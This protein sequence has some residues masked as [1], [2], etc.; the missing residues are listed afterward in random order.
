MNLWWPLTRA[1]G[2]VAWYSMGF[3]SIVGVVLST[4]LFPDRRRPAWLLDAHRWTAGIALVALFTHLVA[5]IADSYV[6]FGVREVLVPYAS[7]WRPGAVALGVVALWITIVIT[8]AAALR[9]RLPRPMWR[10]IHRGAYGAFLLTSLHAAMAGTDATRRVYGAGA[11]LLITAV[12]AA[13]VYRV[14]C[15]EPPKRTRPG[16][17]R[18][19]GAAAVDDG[20]S[21]G[22]PS[23]PARPA[24]PSAPPDPAAGASQPVVVRR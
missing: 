14:A 18:V 11:V 6:H 15:T 23:R 3:S 16:R 21:S 13:L 7:T 5:L 12:S 8:A 22:D 19:A 24:R 20:A 4:R 10:W 1:S 9:R 2:L 17:V